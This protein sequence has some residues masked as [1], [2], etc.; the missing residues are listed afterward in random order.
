MAAALYFS[1]GLSEITG[2]HIMVRK[3]SFYILFIINLVGIYVIDIF[4]QDPSRISGNGNPA[5][6][7]LFFYIPSLLI[8]FLFFGINIY[9]MMLRQKYNYIFSIIFASI[10]FIFVFVWMEY[11]YSIDLI[12]QLGGGP[13]EPNSRIYRFPWLN[14]YTNT[15]FFNYYTF[16]TIFFL[17]IFLSTLFAYIRKNS[18]DCSKG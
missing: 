14:Q 5:I 11:R 16:F 10:A 2:G 9:K 3:Y 15:M 7:I 1:R 6:V 17:I 4:T 8:F 12:F 18:I 13:E